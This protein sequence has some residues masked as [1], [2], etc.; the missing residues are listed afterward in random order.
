M[1]KLLG[2]IQK[3]HT[4]YLH[5]RIPTDVAHHF[6]KAIISESLKTRDRDEAIRRY[7]ARMAKLEQ[8]WQELRSWTPQRLQQ[9][10]S[11]AIAGKLTTDTAVAL[12]VA[13]LRELARPDPHF[14]PTPDGLDEIQEIQWKEEAQREHQRKRLRVFIETG[15][16]LYLD[17]HRR[18]VARAERFGGADFIP[19]P[20]P[21]EV[22]VI[23]GKRRHQPLTKPGERTLS[24]VLEE[25]RAAQSPRPKTYDEYSAKI[26]RFI[27]LHGDL[28]IGA[29]TRTMVSEFMD[30]L[31]QMPLHLSNKESAKPLPEIIDK[32]RDAV[33]D[34]MSHKTVG[35][36][37]QA[38]RTMMNFAMHQ[39]WIESDPTAAIRVNVSRVDAKRLSFTKEHVEKIL[40]EVAQFDDHRFWLPVLACYT[41]ARLEELGQL[42]TGDIRSAGEIAYISIN[43][44]DDKTIKNSGS[45]RDVPIHSAVISAGFLRY[46]A[47]VGDGP[48]FPNLKPDKYGTRMGT[49][50]KRF[51]QML[52]KKIGITD[53][54]LVFHSFRHRYKD[55]C[56]NADIPYDVRDQIM[57]HHDKSAGASYGAGHSLATLDRHV[58]RIDMAIDLVSK[59]YG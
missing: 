6:D 35:K 58:Q 22:T 20:T 25:W 47:S 52:R 16:D 18:E 2:L 23:S 12:S 28:A 30:A 41:G 55:V 56:R 24:A 9:A 8:E 3:G 19:L 46:V 11:M 38:L 14:P 27:E 36:H 45:V 33:R 59:S 21:D 17:W 51:G 40:A 54:R 5:R 7:H 44:Y 10:R 37:V 57:G 53:N 26:R 34:R 50:T 39:G 43:A 48:L 42:T 4:W 49:Y 29:I 31:K 32:Y 13:E 1:A 15:E